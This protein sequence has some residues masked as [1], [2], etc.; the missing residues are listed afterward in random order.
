MTLTEVGLAEI[1]TESVH[2]NPFNPRL[3][4]N[5]E[6]LD[7]LRTS[8]QEIGILVPLI[9]YQDS[10]HPGQYVLLDGERRLRC[11]RDLGLDSVPVNITPE[12]SAIEN[13][14]RMFN[15][16]SVRE[17]WPLISIAL[18]LQNVMN[19]SGE[20][21]ESRLAE[22]TGLTRASVRRAKRLLSLPQQE[23]ELIR[24]EAHLPRNEQVHRE[25][26]Y[27]EIEAAESV[28]RHAFA[29]IAERFTR[30]EII[31]KFAMKRETGNLKA[32]TEF[33]NV[34][35]IVDAASM[36]LVPREEIISAAT[37]LIEDPTINPSEIF[38]DLLSS[39]YLQKDLFKKSTALL[40]DLEELTTPDR[41]SDD[42]RSSLLRLRELIDRLLVV[43][44]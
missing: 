18:S 33:R 36:G 2:P 30:D 14:L 9:V 29:E 26:L 5:E 22:M 38:Q 21:R 41:I 4:F 13:V 39:S 1:P 35:R 6:S 11:A 8:I 16:H 34:S 44:K 19:V 31:R 27:L 15:I 37:A 23:I 43:R 7:L 17:D 32:V 25:D 28:L 20:K 10:K 42:L 3:F 12:P 40:V 24:Q